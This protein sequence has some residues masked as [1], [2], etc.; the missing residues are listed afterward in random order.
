MKLAITSANRWP[1]AIIAVLLGQVAFGVWM[2]RVAGNDPHFAVEPNYYARAVNWD[3][4]MAQ[5]RLDK[6]LGWKATTTLT[7]GAGTAATLHVV[8]VDST[9]AAVKA[10]SVSA[11]AIAIA[12][13]GT[14]DRVAMTADGTG[15]AGPIPTA[16]NGLW[17]VE[18]RAK[19]GADLFTAKLR[20][21][22]K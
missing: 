13:A 9:G 5:S 16:G 20:T 6:A 10:D 14:V 18:V 7:R 21:E 19:R 15:Y 12:H 8:L 3:A 17:E 4:T 2:M 22:L 1:A 11:E